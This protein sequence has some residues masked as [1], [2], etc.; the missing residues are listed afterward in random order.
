MD[1]ASVAQVQAYSTVNE[2]EKAAYLIRCATPWGVDLKVQTGG[3]SMNL[4][5]ISL[6]HIQPI[7]SPPV[8]G[9]GGL[10]SVAIK[11]DSLQEFIVLSFQEYR[12]IFIQVP[13]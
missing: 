1:A 10:I 7:Y 3:F 4:H 11:I 13:V 6:G 8:L 5:E 9:G 2:K 12:G